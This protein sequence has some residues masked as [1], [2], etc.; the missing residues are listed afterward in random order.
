MKRPREGD[1]SGATAFEMSGLFTELPCSSNLLN[2]LKYGNFSYDWSRRHYGSY[3]KLWFWIIHLGMISRYGFI[4]GI[5]V[6]C[7]GLE[8]EWIRWIWLYIVKFNG[9]FAATYFIIWNQIAKACGLF[10]AKAVCKGQDFKNS[11]ARFFLNPDAK[12]N[13]QFATVGW[14]VHGQKFI[15]VPG[16]LVKG[17]FFEDLIYLGCERRSRR[18]IAVL[19]LR[20]GL[21]KSPWKSDPC[22]DSSPFVRKFVGLHKASC[23]LSNFYFW[24]LMDLGED[25]VEID[26]KNGWLP[27]LRMMVVSRKLLEFGSCSI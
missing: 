23:N 18:E 15:K 21:E 14:I 10:F 4:S 20:N 2:S 3:I 24:K 11:A 19:K 5:M 6:L 12:I 17:L 7:W 22:C 27:M 8:V 9:L 1:E 25:W 16:C 26:F 13:G